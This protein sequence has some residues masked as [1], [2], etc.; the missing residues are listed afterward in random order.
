MDTFGGF[1]G[2]R[3][4]TLHTG[5][6]EKPGERQFVCRGRISC[7]PPCGGENQGRMICGPYNAIAFC[8]EGQARRPVT[9]GNPFPA[10]GG[11]LGGKG[12]VPLDRK[13]NPPYPPLTGG[14]KKATSP[15]GSGGIKRRCAPAGQKGPCF[16]LPPCQGGVG[17]VDFT[18]SGVFSTAPQGGSG[19]IMR[20][21]IE[22]SIPC[23]QGTFST[24]P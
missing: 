18:L 3:P 7:G 9:T 21:S 10:S 15:T 17:G 11:F 24:A 16:F 23:F 5:A 19:F 4:S 14:Y 13:T 2:I 22:K 12:D 6:V 1:S 8:V 20:M